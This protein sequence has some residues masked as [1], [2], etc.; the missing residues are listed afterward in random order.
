MNNTSYFPAGGG[1]FNLISDITAEAPAPSPLSLSEPIV[2]AEPVNCPDLFTEN[3]KL[4]HEIKL[5]KQ[6]VKVIK[7]ICGL[8]RQ[9]KIT[10]I[11]E[12]DLHK[13]CQ[14][15]L[16]RF[17][18]PGGES[19]RDI[20]RE[21]MRERERQE[22]FSGQ[23]KDIV[24]LN[25]TTF[26]LEFSRKTEKHYH[27]GDHCV[28]GNHMIPCNGVMFNSVYENNEGERSS[29]STNGIDKIVACSY[30]PIIPAGGG[31]TTI[32]GK[33]YEIPYLF[34]APR[35]RNHQDIN[36][37]FVMNITFPKLPDFMKIENV[38]HFDID[39]YKMKGYYIITYE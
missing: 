25:K 32:A 12:K 27:S 20:E 39:I 17:F 13:Y 8:D 4:K 18:H 11:K 30:G 23:N 6:E 21:R 10:K 3:E 26:D 1:L 38:N 37:W 5:L 14:Y 15:D 35:H 16:K 7:N 22:T 19:E 36:E 24:I 29:I 2:I 31:Q 28:T 33:T 34:L 9:L